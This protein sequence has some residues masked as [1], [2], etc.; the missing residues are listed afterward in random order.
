MPCMSS[1]EPL[2][3]HV[4]AAE[5][6][7]AP[8]REQRVNVHRV[9]VVDVDLPPRG[10]ARELRD[11]L[12]QHAELVHEREEPAARPRPR[13]AGEQLLVQLRV[14]RR[15]LGGSSSAACAARSRAY[16]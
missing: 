5:R 6:E 15:L 8:H 4:A 2:L 9:H 7:E 12:L 1:V 16:G 14:G 3:L 10:D 11:D 13:E